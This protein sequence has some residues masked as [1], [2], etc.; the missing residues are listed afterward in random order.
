MKHAEHQLGLLARRLRLAGLV[1]AAGW[2]AGGATLAGFC[3]TFHW[4][5]DLCSHFRV[6]AGG[7]LAL[8]AIAMLVFRKRW[9]AAVFGALALLNGA[10]IVPLFFGGPPPAAA[11]RDAA[12]MRAMLA[13]VNCESGKPDEVG[14][15]IRRL[16]PDLL[17]LEEVDDRWLMALRP[18]LA[19]YHESVCMPR[20]DSFGIALFSRFPV[21]HSRILT[22][23]EVGVPSILAEIMTPQGACTVLAT[24]PL[25]PLGGAYTRLRNR[26]LAEVP[27]WLQGARSPV[28]LLGDLN[29]T[30]WNHAFVQLVRES[31]LR[32]SERG[33][34]V[35]ASWPTAN[36]L[37]RI[38]LDHCLSGAGITVVSRAIG[39]DVG[40]DHFPLLVAFVLD[41]PASIP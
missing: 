29:T 25:P 30:P 26:Q 35:Q 27:R 1:E 40:S 21:L 16:D 20:G 9:T 12:P 28:L 6:Q 22:L 2:L 33:H 41:A 14:R 19:A 38:P 18:D 39:P 37:L 17:V 3:G 31:G 15:A 4:T 34:G 13:N 10:L 8:A 5:F 7:G 36:V 11:R 32:D 24:H 23:D